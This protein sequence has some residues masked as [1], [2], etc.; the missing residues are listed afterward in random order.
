MSYIF[1]DTIIKITGEL[2]GFVFYPKNERWYDLGLAFYTNGNFFFDHLDLRFS[3]QDKDCG[4][5]IK[6]SVTNDNHVPLNIYTFLLIESL[7]KELGITISIKP[8]TAN[9][10][11]PGEILKKQ[12]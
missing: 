12:L 11:F 4:V 6:S 2:G 5:I 1:L 8:F 9:F 10:Y 3:R 7:E